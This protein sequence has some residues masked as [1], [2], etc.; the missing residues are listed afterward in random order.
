[1][2]EQRT[3]RAKMP[4][5][6]EAFADCVKNE[7]TVVVISHSLLVNMD[8][9]L[10]ESRLNEE[11]KKVYKATGI[12]GLIVGI[13]DPPMWIFAVA[14][15]MFRGILKEKIKG[16]DVYSGE[17]VKG[18]NIIVLIRKKDYAPKYDKIIYDKDYVKCVSEKPMRGKIKA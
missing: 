2:R 10:N 4:T 18:E 1:M 16:Y 15:F 3:F 14:C 12:Y 11:V 8:K 5:T 6:Q 9:E 7:K 17:D 13:V